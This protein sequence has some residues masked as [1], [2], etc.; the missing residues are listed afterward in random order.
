MK[1]EQLIATLEAQLRDVKQHRLQ[2]RADAGLQ[3]ARTAVKNY[4]ASRLAQ[5][6]ADLLAAP[7]TREAA[8]FFLEE[9]YSA[10][11][12]SQRDTDLERII[13]TLKKVLPY[14]P[15]KAVTEAI[16][17]DALSE[18]LDTAMA[19]ALGERFDEARYLEAY[20]RVTTR[21]ER[22]HQ[23][24][25]VRGLG[26]SLCSIVKIPMLSLTLSMMAGPAKLAGLADLHEFLS[27]GF[28]T[29]KRMPQPERFIAT[30]T[31]R[32]LV[33]LDEIYGGDTRP[34]SAR[35]P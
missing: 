3:A 20:R 19:L 28:N 23:L 30:I 8:R 1:K 22:T 33:I 27:K 26:E 4:Q 16:V 9:L 2:A 15:L 13:P 5:T 10:H 14:E 18:R 12:L 32:E 7:D 34:F 17:L 11:D 24:E 29:F 31:E 21:A 35:R 25:L 6:H